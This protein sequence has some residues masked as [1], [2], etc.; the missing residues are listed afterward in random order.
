MFTV[1][2]IDDEA[3]VRI[4]LKS[5]INWEDNDCQIVAEASNGQQG[6]EIIKKYR[7]DIVISDIKMPVMDGIG[8]MQELDIK[9]KTKFIVLSS[10][11][12]FNLVRQTMKLGAIEYLIKLELEQSTLINA[13]NQAKKLILLENEECERKGSLERQVRVNKPVLREEFFRKLVGHQFI[14]RKELDENIELLEIDLNE[15][16]LICVFIKVYEIDNIAEFGKEDIQ[17]FDFSAVNIIDEILNDTFKG[18]V[19]KWNH[20]EYVAVFSFNSNWSRE[21]LNDKLSQVMERLIQML[22]QYFNISVSIGISDIH[23]GFKELG[24]AFLQS[25]QAVES[26]FFKGF[27][28]YTFYNECC[29]S[30]PIKETI[31]IS[32]FKSRLKNAM[33]LSDANEIRKIFEDVNQL[34]SKEKVT[35][36]KAYDICCHFAYLVINVIDEKL[37]KPVMGYEVSIFTEILRQNSLPEIRDWLDKFGECLCTI[38]ENSSNNNTN[39]LIIKAKKYINDHIKEDIKLNELAAA[40][41]LSPGYLSTLFKQV[42]GKN[43]IDYTTE[44]KIEYAKKLLKESNLKIYQ[45]SDFMG[46]ENAYYFSRVFRKVTGMTPREFI[47]KQQI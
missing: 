2:I 14:D 7:P 8:M 12:E 20:A 29:N 3:L 19:F 13:I 18:Y 38:M 26:G 42:T 28:S 17:L 22:K 11:D 40:L 15:N 39:R 45:V 25:N 43:F 46:Y 35:K 5:M 16:S 41:A 24:T 1:V 9:K 30:G 44:V 6:L 36:Q 21:L 34:L 10:Y 37:F 47:D 31:E 27:G 33:E 23:M 4:G 32:D